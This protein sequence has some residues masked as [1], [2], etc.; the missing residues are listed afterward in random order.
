MLALAAKPARVAGFGELQEFLE[1]G[2]DAF[3]HMGGAAEFLQTV[4]T[5]E[6]AILERLFAGHPRP[7]AA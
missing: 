7:F 4:E 6:K 3:R 1:R 2:F 5:R